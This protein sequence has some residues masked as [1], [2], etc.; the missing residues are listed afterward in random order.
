MIL[1]TAAGG[2]VGS[3]LV[4]QLSE[5]KIAARAGFHSEAKAKT[6]KLPGI[7]PVVLDFRDPASVRNAMGGVDKVFLATPG[8]PDQ[9]AAERTIVDEAKATGVKHVVKVSVIGA[10]EGGIV[11]AKWS[12]VVELH[13]EQSGIAFTFLRP[14]F[15]MQNFLNFAESI[16]TKGGF[17]LGRGD[18]RPCVI[19]ARDIA[20]VGVKVLTETGHANRAYELNGPEAISYAQVA[21]RL[22][23]VLAK[24]VAYWNIP[25]A[26]FKK[27]FMA[28]G[29][30]EWMADAYVDLADW[31]ASG[32]GDKPTPVLGELL[33]RAP[34]TFDQFLADNL[35]SFA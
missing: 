25:A 26:E 8:T 4:K 29:A 10:L 22:T 3:S 5:K 27:G 20:A 31:Y 32:H 12:R 28:V 33:G 6:L 15:F 21:E 2:K 9:P 24:P 34:R 23:K 7:E 14:N 18:A 13:I 30:P 11:F 35:T 19:D 1:V 16:K 17:T